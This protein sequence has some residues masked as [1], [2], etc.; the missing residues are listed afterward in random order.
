MAPRK[1]WIVV[2]SCLSCALVPSA[3]SAQEVQWRTDYA[4]AR[5]ESDKKS[6]PLLLNIGTENCHWCR[7]LDEST[8][9]DP[10]VA[11]LMNEQ[12]VP[13]RVDAH[14]ET[15]LAQAL[16]VKSYPTLVF[17]APN[18]K[19]LGSFEGYLDAAR[20]HESLQRVL[21]S[22]DSPEWMQRDQQLAKEAIAKGDFARAVTLL[23]NIVQD[24]KARPV[25]VASDKLLKEIEQ[26][27]RGRLA[28]AKQLQDKGLVNEA[29]DTLAS[30][31][32]DFAGLTPAREATEQLRALA[33]TTDQV[34]EQRTRRAQELLA[35]A[36]KDYQTQQYIPFL[37]RCET[38]RMHYGDLPE[39]VEAMQLTEDLRNNPEWL[40]SACETLSDRLGGLYRALAESWISRG[41]FQQA[42]QYLEVVVRAFPGSRQAQAAQSRLDQLRHEM[43]RRVEYNPR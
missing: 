15:Q 10:A 33:K 6:L 39:A 27:A 14:K 42:R 11:R 9:R 40:L 30:V 13:L 32:R 23:K 8:F 43:S 21:A 36:K 29:T 24:G 12:F 5:R 2:L 22:V 4:A 38:L 16:Q 37:D 7:R 34:T 41:Q 20:L 35:Q 28:K 1:I 26:T 19:I 3:G 31:E 25:Q 17:A 18:G